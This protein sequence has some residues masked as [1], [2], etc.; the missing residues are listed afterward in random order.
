MG[1]LLHHQ[2]ELCLGG[3]AIT[4]GTACRAH[5][6]QVSGVQA[7]WKL[8]SVM[9]SLE[10]HMSSEAGLLTHFTAEQTEV[11]KDGVSLFM[12]RVGGKQLFL[13]PGP[14]RPHGKLG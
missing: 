8:E 6:P 13:A 4:C 3:T 2:S 1:T 10:P 11:Q 12:Q 7:G 14:G 5:P 9:V